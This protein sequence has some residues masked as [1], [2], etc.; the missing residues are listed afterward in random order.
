MGSSFSVFSDPKDS[1]EL[2][3]SSES[4]SKS[5]TDFEDISTVI[6]RNDSINPSCTINKY[7]EQNVA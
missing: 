2:E 7:N 3:N 4:V 6:S 5:N 1:Q